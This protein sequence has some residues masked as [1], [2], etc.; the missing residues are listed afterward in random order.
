MIVFGVALASV[1]CAEGAF[2]VL[3][4]HPSPEMAGLYAPFGDGAYK[5]QANA[6]TGANWA[7]GKF[8]VITDGLGLRCDSALELASH[9][10]EVLDALIVGDSQGFGN[11]VNFEY[12]VAG[13]A[14]EAAHA[15][16]LNIANSSVGGHVAQNQFELVQWLEQAHQLT[17]RNYVLLLTPSMTVGCGGYT[18]E[19]VGED[20][21][22]YDQP[23]SPRERGLI[24]L[25]S[26]SVSYHRFRNAVRG[27]G[28]GNRASDSNQTLFYVYG[29]GGLDELKARQS[30]KEYVARFHDYASAH[31]ARLWL[32]YVPLT[33]EV[34][35]EP[36]L[37]A[38]KAKGVTLDRDLPLRLCTEVAAESGLPLK[39][40]R[41][42]LEQ[43]KAA[44]GELHLKGDYHY[45]AN[46]SKLCGLDLWQWLEPA[47]KNN[48]TSK[49]TPHTLPLSYDNGN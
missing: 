23:K 39:S 35:F 18:R 47:L 12:S 49:T 28:I 2:R 20:G 26:N 5:L 7:S 10:G 43:V 34:E 46:T 33:V 4:D 11:G 3:G 17:A 21:R 15:C 1:F 31:G 45:C 6:R 36:V 30:L 9:D 44:S 48:V 25:K 38:G 16:G 32:V 27:L 29:G 37:Q 22:L 13:V 40:L 24:A 14:A 42:V 8:S 19:A 41:P